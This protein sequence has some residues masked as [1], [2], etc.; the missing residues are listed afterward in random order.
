MFG[1]M[2]QPELFIELMGF[3]HNVA[4]KG[5]MLEEKQRGREA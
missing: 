1:H 4:A 5:L 3:C 2:E